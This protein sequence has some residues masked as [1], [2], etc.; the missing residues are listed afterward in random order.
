MQLGNDQKRVFP[1]CGMWEGMYFS[2]PSTFNLSNDILWRLRLVATAISTLSSHVLRRISHTSRS[3]SHKRGNERKRNSSQNAHSVASFLIR[4]LSA[5]SLKGRSSTC[6][7]VEF[8]MMVP[9]S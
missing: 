5:Q 9:G 6:T 8:C 7:I 2:L 1:H 3:L 4:V